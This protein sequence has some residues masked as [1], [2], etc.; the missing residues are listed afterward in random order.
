[1]NQEEINMHLAA[2]RYFGQLS[3]CGKKVQHPDLESALKHATALNSVKN[4]THDVEP[5]PCY[6]CSDRF[7]DSH[8][9][10][11]V[12]LYWHVGR[13]MTQDERR[14]WNEIAKLYAP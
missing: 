14:A 9:S 7:P 3:T 11:L 2:G 13:T 5:Y 12:H 6:W 1:M 8:E 10:D 4:R